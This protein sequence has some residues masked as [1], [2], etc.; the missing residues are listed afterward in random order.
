MGQRRH[1]GADAC[2]AGK[3]RNRRLTTAREK[4]HREAHK[5]ELDMS[6]VIKGGTVVTAD[7]TFKADVLIDGETIAAIGPGLT[8]DTVI[9][10]TGCFVMP[11]GIDPHTHLE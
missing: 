9:D 11:G 4:R 5:R 2:R 8:G 3:G 7:Q 10:A 1:A 6:V